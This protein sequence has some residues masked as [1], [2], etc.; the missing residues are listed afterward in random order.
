MHTIVG[1]DLDLCVCKKPNHDDAEI[2]FETHMSVQQQQ[3]AMS[4]R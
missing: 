4:E 2:P 3:D 1:F